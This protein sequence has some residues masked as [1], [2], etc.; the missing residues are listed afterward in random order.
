MSDHS[1]PAEH[2]HD[3]HGHEGHHGSLMSH[4]KVYLIIGALL[5]I[6]TVITVALS[7]IDFAHI[8]IFK[9]AFGLVGLKGDGINIVIGLIVATFK[10][11]LVGAWFMHLKQETMQIWRP[12]LF[13]FFF[14]FAL[15]M[16]FVLAYLDPIP[17]S[18]HWFH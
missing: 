11:C 8:G 10:V 2:K 12:L 5:F 13:T 14:V 17:S 3:A 4:S 6:F 9:W 15:F 18:S 7:Y 16:L 1:T